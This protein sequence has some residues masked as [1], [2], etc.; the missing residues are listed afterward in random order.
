MRWGEEP[1]HLL[2]DLVA[3]QVLDPDGV[4]LL[5]PEDEPFRDIYRRTL[6]VLERRFD[7]SLCPCYLQEA[8]LPAYAVRGTP[9]MRL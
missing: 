1:D 4:T 7:L 2:P 3:G 6:G 8:R 5:A 9:A